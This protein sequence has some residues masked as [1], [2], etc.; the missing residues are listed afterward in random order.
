MKSLR[1]YGDPMLPL[2]LVN[3]TP[4]T[5]ALGMAIKVNK[6]AVRETVTDKLE[7]TLREYFSFAN[8]DFGQHVSQDEVLAVAHSVD[9][10]EAVRITRLYKKEPGSLEGIESIIPSHLPFASLTVAPEPAEL[11]TL[12]DEPLEMESF[13]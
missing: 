3:F 1:R 2:S 12:S 6:A 13:L 9:H 5:F 7:A 8:R 11:L 4:A 10:V